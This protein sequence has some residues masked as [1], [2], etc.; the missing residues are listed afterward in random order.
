MKSS[1][2]IV[3]ICSL[4][5]NHALYIRECLDGI[6]MQQCDFKFEILIHD[7]ASTDGTQEIIKEY[8]KN[9]PGIIKPIFRK[10][11]LYSQGKRGFY[12]R[13]LYPNARGK[14]IALCEGDDYWTDPLKLQKQVDFLDAN[15][16][17]ILVSTGVINIESERN[18]D[19]DITPFDILHHN[20]IKTLTAMFRKINLKDFKS[21][22]YNIGD[23][24]LWLF[25]VQRGKFKYIIDETAY[26]RVLE[27]SISGRNSI[28]KQINFQIEVIQIIRGNIQNFNLTPVQMKKI[29]QDRY[30]VL[31]SKCLKKNKTLAFKFYVKS[32]LDAKRLNFTD[33][34]LLCNFI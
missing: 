10:K 33:V 7:D 31:I 22:N 11:N 12:A 13:F 25:L 14:Y 19:T 23:L 28:D 17:Y 4:T 20:P 3:S 15:K 21:K 16:N 9:Y 8:Q 5:Y 1:D 6:L 27:N 34:K 26:Y 2:I 32:I 29:F 30:S 24:Q 18:S